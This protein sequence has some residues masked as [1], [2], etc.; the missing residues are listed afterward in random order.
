M[1]ARA[2]G[3]HRDAAD[4]DAADGS[5]WLPWLV[6]M[7]WA[8][9]AGQ[10]LTVAVARWGL[11]LE[12]Q[13]GW[14]LAIVAFTAA[15]N[16]LLAASLDR[17]AGRASEVAAAVIA[18]DVVLL[19]ALLGLSGGAANPFSVLYLV[20]V[21]LAAL[22]FGFR[23]SLAIAGLCAA[24]YA[25][26][27]AVH[28]PLMDHAGH[29]GHDMGHGM[30]HGPGS[31]DLHL[32]GMW[33]ATVVAALILSY[34]VAR[35]ASALRERD[36]QLRALER[37]ASRNEKL[38]ALSALAAGAAHELGSP[39]GTIAVAASELD[40]AAQR[41]PGAEALAE[42]ARL[43]REQAARCREILARMSGE[44]GADLGEGLDPIDLA[45]LFGAVRERLDAREWQ[46]LT[47]ACAAP[48]A[49]LRAPRT[50]LAQAL[51]NLVRNGLAAAPERSPVSLDASVH[52]EHVRFE[53][54]DGGGGMAPDVLAR[55]GEPFFS[56]RPAGAGMGLGL[57]LSRAVAERLG[58]RL[59]LE[60]DP[61]GGTR[62][63]LEVRR[64]PLERGAA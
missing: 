3:T 4:A 50:A 29:G 47:V 13:L 15:S 21:S 64:D 48:D 24:C 2:P 52:G 6:R 12:I 32:Q 51:V 23:W 54:R 17:L 8:A 53:V 56:T 36:A 28:A 34:F 44:A 55:A 20:H 41:M 63:V 11:G 35:T 25:T 46:R 19:T 60:A 39:L 5:A 37:A 26:I 27:F 31:I 30:S 22:L 38:V 62:A 14:L 40:R 57:F 45:A 7:R 9:V 42:D 16:A 49:T 33:A 59:S 43:I 58:G 18:L 61:D 10:L 1:T